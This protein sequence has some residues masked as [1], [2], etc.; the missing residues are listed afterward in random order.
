MSWQ[1]HI[2]KLLALSVIFL[3]WIDCRRRYSIPGMV[4]V[5][6]VVGV[7][8]IRDI[9]GIVYP[10]PLV[11][12]ATDALLPLGYLAIARP[13]TGWKN[14]DLVVGALAVAMIVGMSLLQ[15][16][17]QLTVIPAAILTLSY[18]SGALANVAPTN[19]RSPEFVMRTRVNL[20]LLLAVGIGAATAAGYRTPAT[21]VVIYPLAYFVHLLVVKRINDFR[22]DQVQA[23]LERAQTENEGLFKFMQSLGTALAQHLEMDQVLSFIVESAATTADASGAALLMIDGRDGALHVRATTGRFAPPYE[24]PEL[25]KQRRNALDQYIRSRPVELGET[26]LGEAT[27]EGS[28][29]LVS[30]VAEDDR[31]SANHGTGVLYISSFMALPL[32]IGG[33]VLGVVGLTRDQPDF[34]FTESDLDHA[35]T[36]ADY[37]A[38]T[39]DILFTYIEVMEKREIEREIGIAAEIQNKLIPQRVPQLTGLETAV[40]AKPA[41]GVSGDY[42]DILKLSDSR[43]GFLMCDVAGKGVPAALVMVIINSLLHLVASPRYNAAQTVTLINRGLSGKIEIDHYATLSYLTYDAE[44]RIVEYS[45]AAHHPLVLFRA[46]TG[47][48]EHVDTEGL[49]IGI[50]GTMR[51]Q[52]RRFRARE[53]DLLLLYTDGVIEAMNDAGEQYG[54]DRLLEVFETAA[55]GDTD[56][57]PIRREEEPGTAATADTDA[58]ATE[59]ATRSGPAVPVETKH[60]RMI[61]EAIQVDIDRHVGEARQ[62]DDQTLLVVRF[63]PNGSGSNGRHA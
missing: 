51:Y 13:Y 53:S 37:A 43:M 17:Y 20:G 32:I 50:E 57:E 8:F 52:Q 26:A 47:R 40:Y 24:V 4:S 55:R 34:L 11:Y 12:A 36:F 41:R 18:T 7:L 30:N 16:P 6:V 63:G 28:A 22:T 31:F 10:N 61:C 60:P 35:Q 54:L 27:Q 9:V 2:P 23:S 39:I 15:W 21:H 1:E 45:N 46:S 48:I 14:T 44:S 29:I 19:T 59:I 38:L 3:T 56:G 25:V 5:A 62:H 49:P 42:Y 58:A 33:R